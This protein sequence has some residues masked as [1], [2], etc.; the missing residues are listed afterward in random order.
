[1]LTIH[2]GAVRV[3]HVTIIVGC[4]P[5]NVKHHEATACCDLELDIETE[6][7]EI[8]MFHHF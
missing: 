6:L 1:M 3:Q 7:N 5:D 4:L 2:S 8:I